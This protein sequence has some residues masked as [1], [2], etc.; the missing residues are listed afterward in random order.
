MSFADPAA[1]T[2]NGV[3][4]NLV[5]IRQDGYSSEYLL[6]STTDELRFNIRNTSYMD[7]KRKVMIDRHNAELV[8]TVFPVAPAVLSTVRK[9]YLVIE[10]QQGDTLTD[11][12]N[13]AL[14]MLA[15]LSASSGANVTRMLNLE[16]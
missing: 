16:S 15:Y 12:L 6:R 13:V 10:N 8:Q 1:I 3:A 9:V 11:P 5:R 14:G 4:K 2:I 7:K